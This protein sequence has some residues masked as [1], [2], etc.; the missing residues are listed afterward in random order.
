MLNY[1]YLNLSIYVCE[2]PFWRLKSRP[3]LPIL[4]ELYTCEVIITLMVHGGNYSRDYLRNFPQS[5]VEENFI[6]N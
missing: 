6:H 3:L 4:Q 1:F 5:D 2:V